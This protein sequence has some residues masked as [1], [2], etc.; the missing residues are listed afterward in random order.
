MKIVK[1][2]WVDSTS[3]NGGWM[4]DLDYDLMPITTV[5]HL[6]LKDKEKVIISHSIGNYKTSDINAMDFYDIYLI[7]RGCIKTMEVIG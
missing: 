5:G 4:R 6:L 7:P 1:V 2:T 3:I